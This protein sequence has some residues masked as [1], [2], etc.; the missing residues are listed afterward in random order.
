LNAD[1]RQDYLEQPVSGL[2]KTHGR[3]SS[4]AKYRA[5][6]ITSGVR[7]KRCWAAQ[8]YLANGLSRVKNANAARYCW[9]RTIDSHMR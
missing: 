8:R 2:H 3:F 9:S 6:A 5:T 1:D 4:E 7:K